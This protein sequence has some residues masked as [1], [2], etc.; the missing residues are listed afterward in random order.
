MRGSKGHLQKNCAFFLVTI[1]K[2]EKVS[3]S[4]A[5]NVFSF[6]VCCFACR[7]LVVTFLL[8]G[9][10]VVVVYCALLC[11]VLC[12]FVCWRHVLSLLP[13]VVSCLSCV[14]LASCLVMSCRALSCRVLFVAV[15]LLPFGCLF[16]VCS[17]SFLCAVV[18]ILSF[19]CVSFMSR[20]LRSS[21]QVNSQLEELQVRHMAFHLT[22]ASAPP[23]K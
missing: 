6:P 16:R 11:R 18:R 14:F 10:P 4:P 13:S 12:L 3:V 2:D 5:S 1:S 19:Q 15:P 20:S 7:V 21:F 23:P 22:L 17:L 8:C 9:F